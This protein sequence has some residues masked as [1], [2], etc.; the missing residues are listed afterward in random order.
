MRKFRKASYFF[1]RYWWCLKTPIWLLTIF[2]NNIFYFN[3][4]LFLGEAGWSLLVRL[5]YFILF[6]W[7]SCDCRL[8]I[9]QSS[10]LDINATDF[11]KMFFAAKLF[12]KSLGESTSLDLRRPEPIFSWLTTFLNFCYP[13]PTWL[14]LLSHL[15]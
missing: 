5:R 11:R 15:S 6:S 13:F 4:H 7:A 2:I 1:L 12:A 10:N 14:W 3:S 9:L 8:N